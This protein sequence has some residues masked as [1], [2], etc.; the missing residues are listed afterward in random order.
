[1]LEA[2]VVKVEIVLVILLLSVDVL[3]VLVMIVVGIEAVRLVLDEVVVGVTVV[4][5]GATDVL[6]VLVMM[7]VG[8]EAVLLVL[9]EVVGVVMVSGDGP[10][11]VSGGATESLAEAGAAPI[12][13]MFKVLSDGGGGHAG[14]VE[15]GGKTPGAGI[16][17][18]GICKAA[19]HSEI[20]SAREA[21][22]GGL[23]VAKQLMQVVISPPVKQGHSPAL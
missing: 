10:I 6:D 15:A 22:N 23:S 11:V 20:I 16:S 21:A 3:D 2:V 12:I 9:D 17:L 5:G 14:G 1:V 13:G 7:V 19:L 4:S 18:V 8:I